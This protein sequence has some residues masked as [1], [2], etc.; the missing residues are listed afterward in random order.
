VA[1]QLGPLLAQPGFEVGDERGA[2]FLPDGPTLLGALTVNGAFDLEQRVDAADRFQGQRRDH[3][4]RFAVRL[5]PGIG[6]NIGQDEER[7]ASVYPTR[8][9]DD[10]PRL[11][12][13]LVQLVVAAIGIGLEDPGIAG[14]MPGRVLAAAITRIVEYRRRRVGPGER[15]VIP[16]IRP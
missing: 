1:R 13:G 16:Y 3:A 10:R 9:L 7:P 12:V 5:A 8:R 15:P 4:R 11:A 14:Q 2:Q 6:L